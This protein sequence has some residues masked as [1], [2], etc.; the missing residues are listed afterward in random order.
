MV[1]HLLGVHCSTVVKQH[2]GK[3][4]YYNRKHLIRLAYSFRGLVYY[5]HGGFNI[6]MQTD[7]G[8]GVR[9]TFWFIGKEGL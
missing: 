5:H 8:A 6:S 9:V 3:W 1:E 7:V 2:H 4:N